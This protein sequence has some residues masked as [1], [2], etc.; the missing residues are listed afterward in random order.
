MLDPTL[1]RKIES[2]ARPLRMMRK[3]EAAGRCLSAS[4]DLADQAQRKHGAALQ[5]VKWRVVGDPDYV[6]HW[7]VLR[8][9]DSVWDLTRVQV[10]GLRELVHGLGSYPANFQR[11]QVVP[12]ALFLDAYRAATT[13]SISSRLPSR[14]LWHCGV[15][16]LRYGLEQ[17]W[18]QRC[19]PMALTTAAEGG[20]FLK[21]F[22]TSSC[23]RWLEQRSRQLLER[24]QAQPSMSARSMVGAPTVMT[25]SRS[26]Q[27]R[28]EEAIWRAGTLTLAANTSVVNMVTVLTCL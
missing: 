6:D 25:Q 8:S 13:H 21:C 20:R 27:T 19:L 10:D 4:L 9:N 12:A 15:S 22:W 28:A 1:L 11:Q 24:L 23:T 2:T 7:A 5:L 16:L 18:Q 14:F 17:A 3:D 26:L